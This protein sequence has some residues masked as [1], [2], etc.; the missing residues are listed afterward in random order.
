MSDR[1]RRNFLS[2]SAKLLVGTAALSTTGVYASSHDQKEHPASADGV[3]VN[4]DAK[5][6][7]ATCQFWG[8]MR[9]VSKDKKTIS[10][11]TMG[12]CN[13]ENSMNYQKLTSA[14]RTMKKTGIWKKWAAL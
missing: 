14:V 6:I 5:Y 10:V 8:G 3:T 13:N 12:W 4:A 7:C 2:T 11:Q 9:K 1:M